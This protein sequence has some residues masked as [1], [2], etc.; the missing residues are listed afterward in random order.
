MIL[1][2]LFYF[3][4]YFILYLIFYNTERVKVVKGVPQNSTLKPG[5]YVGHEVIVDQ[6][7]YAATVISLQTITGWKIDREVLTNLIS[8]EKLEGSA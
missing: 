5:D 7:K 4:S 1:I 3:A 6:Q 2:V 8:V